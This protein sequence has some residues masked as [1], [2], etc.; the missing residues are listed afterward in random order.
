MARFHAIY[1]KLDPIVFS[2]KSATR[3]FQWD[4]T[5]IGKTMQYFLVKYAAYAKY[6]RK[7]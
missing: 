6:I 5:G 4:F 2:G 1:E 7:F 3:R